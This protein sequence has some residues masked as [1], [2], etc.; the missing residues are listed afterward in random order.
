M[1]N[2]WYNLNKLSGLLELALNI[3]K[4]SIVYNIYKFINTIRVRQH[5]YI[6]D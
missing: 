4:Q 1:D 2:N 6:L 3:K 5:L